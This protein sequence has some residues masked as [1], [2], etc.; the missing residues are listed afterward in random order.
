L[1]K[2]SKG[3][4]YFFAIEKQWIHIFNAYTLV[5]IAKIKHSGV[6]ATELVFAEHDHAFAIVSSCGF[7]GK[8][9]IP[10]FIQ[11]V[12]TDETE[13][14]TPKHIDFVK[15]PKGEFVKE[16]DQYS[17]VIVGSKKNRQCLKII[18]K[19]NKVSKF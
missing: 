14:A 2:Y 18:N 17:L 3:G 4:Q 12:Q 5:E 15:Y 19:E 1:I 16:E 6:K 8:W 9:K 11:I 13:W 7:V 10:D